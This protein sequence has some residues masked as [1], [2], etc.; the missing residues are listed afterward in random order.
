M[1]ENTQDFTTLD[2]KEEFGK[3]IKAAREAQYLSVTDVSNKTSIS[4]HRI[5]EIESGITETNNAMQRVIIIKY[6]KFLGIYNDE[7][8]EALDHAYEN[9]VDALTHTINIPQ[10]VGDVSFNEE[11]KKSKQVKTVKKNVKATVIVVILILVIAALGFLI[12]KSFK[13]NVEEVTTNETTLIQN[14]TLT[15]E[16]VVDTKAKITVEDTKTGY[17]ISG[18][19]DYDVLISF[20]GP[21]FVEI[22]NQDVKSRSYDAGDEITFSVKAGKKVVIKTGKY[23]NLKISVNGE[24]LTPK[25]LVGV[26]TINLVFDKTVPTSEQDSKPNNQ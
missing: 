20:S 11:I 25:N 15:P 18:G 1:N 26:Q 13:S 9:N 21:S 12:Y 8:K 22:P 6:L 14:T 16:Q 7:T 19:E 17:S 23:E 5:N 24:E 2:L 4:E 3:K 10:T